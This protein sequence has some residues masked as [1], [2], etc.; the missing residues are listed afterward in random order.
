M[1]GAALFSAVLV[2]PMGLWSKATGL[3]VLATLVAVLLEWA[4]GILTMAYLLRRASRRSTEQAPLPITTVELIGQRVAWLLPGSLPLCASRLRSVDRPW[5]AV[6][7]A[8]T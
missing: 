8:E 5:R 6:T 2:V 1:S 3:G 4:A 7:R